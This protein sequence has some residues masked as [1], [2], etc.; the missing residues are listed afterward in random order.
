M[1]SIKTNRLRLLM[2]LCVFSALL[3]STTAYAQTKKISGT[4]TN[5]RNSAPAAGATIIVKNTNRSTIADENGKFTIDASNGDVLVITMIGFERKE[6]V[7]GNNNTIKV[8]LS[9]IVSRLDDVVVIGYGKTQR[10]DVTG[11]ISSITGE[12]LR[13]TQPTTFDQ[14]LQGKVAGVVVQ[15]VS[16]QPGGGVSIQINGVSS[17]T[18]SNSPLYVIDGVIIP[19]VGDPGKWFKSVKYH[20]SCRN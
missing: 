10:K 18:G 1:K 19:P 7:V 11:A 20:Q 17:I 13:K 3:V 9:E 15:Q 6:V 14:A 16:G 4:V 2:L 5:Q 8:R 12:E